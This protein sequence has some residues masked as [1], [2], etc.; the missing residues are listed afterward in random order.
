MG[1]LRSRARR[2]DASADARLGNRFALHERAEQRGVAEGTRALP[3][4]PGGVL[5]ARGAEPAL[6]RA[7]EA[8][9]R[10]DARPPPHPR[11]DGAGRRTRRRGPRGRAPEALQRHHGRARQALQRLPKPRARRDEG[12]FPHAHYADRGGGSARAAEGDDG[13]RRRPGEGAV[14]GDDR[15]G[16]LL[17]VHEA[18]PQPSR[19]RGAPARPRHAR[20]VGRARQHAAHRPHPRA[21]A[22]PREGLPPRLQ[23]LRR[24]LACHEVRAVRRRGAG[25]GG[26]AGRR[27]EARQGARGRRARRVRPGK[28]RA[29][30]HC[31]LERTPAREALL[32]LGGGADAVLQF[33]RRAEGPVR[34]RRTPLRRD[35]RGA[36]RRRAR[37]ASRRALL[38]RV[39]GR[40]RN[41][42]FLPRPL[43]APPSTPTRAPRRSRAAPG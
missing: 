9:A 14:E 33:P 20:L 28:N 32:L 29:L 26:R 24:L 25:D 40:P 34:N 42:A 31:V 22:A 16:R 36:D 30:G 10:G 37:V 3:A 5:T 41:R 43:L 38:P 1:R 19:A 39:R 17:P 15:G 11:Q 7:R 6:L 12:L 21:A 2:R 13:G 35:N 4:R 23:N 18:L 8:D 27:L